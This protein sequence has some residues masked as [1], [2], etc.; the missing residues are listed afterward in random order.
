MVLK[1][2][3]HLRR[4]GLAI[5]ALTASGAAAGLLALQATIDGHIRSALIWLIICQVLDGVDGPIARKFSVT[6]YAPQF[7][8]HILDLVVDYVTC[9]IVPVAFM[10]RMD[11]LPRGWQMCVGA[12]IVFTSALWFARS[13]LETPD[14]WFNGFPAA[15]NVVVPTF[16]ILHTGP[17]WATIISIA[18]C[19]LQLT[20]VKFPHLMRVT[21]MRKFTIPLML[22]YLLAL[23]VLSATY[24]SA[25]RLNGPRWAYLLLTLTPLY[26]VFIVVWRTWFS[27]RKIFGASILS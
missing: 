10:V 24:E 22:L 15:W 5:H 11:L 17:V 4:A 16:L 6:D 12:L 26:M 18:L 1:Q 14:A 13:D 8:G 25:D 2:A 3:H 21:T 19:L 7:D 20:N 27:E 23:T 9:V